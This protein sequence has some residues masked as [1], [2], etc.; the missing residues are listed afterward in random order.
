MSDPVARLLRVDARDPGCE[1]GREVVEQVIEIDLAGGD[2]EEHF[3]GG[4]VHLE[5]CDG[6]RSDY[7]GLREA[8]SMIAGAAPPTQAD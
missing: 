7:E 4:L 2:P 3:P 8:A 6:C 5:S 1:A